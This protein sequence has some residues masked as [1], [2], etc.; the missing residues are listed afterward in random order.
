MVL[1]VSEK[2]GVFRMNL[3]Q[4]KTSKWFFFCYC[5]VILIFALIYLI[6][7]NI[8]VDN[9][10]INE[11][12]NLRPFKEAIKISWMSEINVEY[13]ISTERLTSIQKQYLVFL[14]N[15]NQVKSKMERAEKELEMLNKDRMAIEK[16]HSEK[17]RFNTEMFEYIEISD[18]ERE[19]LKIVSEIDTLEKLTSSVPSEALSR[20]LINVANKKVDL[21]TVRHKKA[22]KQYEIS[23]YI[24]SNISKFADPETT[25]TIKELNKRELELFKEQNENQDKMFN[26]R[27][28]LQNSIN[29]WFESRSNMLNFI[30]FLYYSIGISTTTTF[31]DIVANG[32]LLRFIV[33]TQLVLCIIIVG[34]FINSLVPN[35]PKQGPPSES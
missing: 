35:N 7:W 12:L 9:F 22:K 2:K 17:W 3:I 5:I 4:G 14:N 34:A 19:E 21:A 32:K 18:I 23:S 13:P 15:M 20:H 10:I 29:E 27:N 31:G 11:E 25:A 16:K 1:N 26:L 30:D 33:S 8:S 6:F 28:Q 24:L